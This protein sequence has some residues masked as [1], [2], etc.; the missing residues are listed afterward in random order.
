MQ[1]SQIYPLNTDPSMSEAIHEDKIVKLLAKSKLKSLPYNHTDHP[2]PP[3]HNFQSSLNKSIQVLHQHMRY[4][5]NRTLKGYLS[6]HSNSSK[7]NGINVR[8]VIF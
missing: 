8:L 3:T 7:P 6:K 1:H 4:H 5:Y 2:P